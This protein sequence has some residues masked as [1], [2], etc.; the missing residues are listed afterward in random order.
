MQAPTQ[1]ARKL[2]DRRISIR[3]PT[4]PPFPPAFVI[5]RHPLLSAP[6]SIHVPCRVS[7]FRQ[8][9]TIRHSL[10]THKPQRQQDA[11]R[12]HP[13]SA[14]T[15][16]IGIRFRLFLLPTILLHPFIRSLS[17]AI[18]VGVSETLV[19]IPMITSKTRV[20]P[21][22]TRDLLILAIIFHLQ[23]RGGILRSSFL[24]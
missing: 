6:R 22:L 21:Q 16:H 10:L 9:T 23:H 12:M 4:H 18:S 24:R 3:I 2:R 14:S 19:L 11:G 7:G 8:G 1:P 17:S 13:I 15:S 5:S 20:Q